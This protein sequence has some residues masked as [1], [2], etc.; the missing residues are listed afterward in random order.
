MNRILNLR[1][2]PGGVT[3]L[4]LELGE[5]VETCFEKP[6]ISYTHTFVGWTLTDYQSDALGTESPRFEYAC[7]SAVYSIALVY[8]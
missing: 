7:Y 1:S 4:P 5:S 2:I 6:I 8:T 3:S